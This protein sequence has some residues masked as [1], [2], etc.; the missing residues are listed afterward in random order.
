[1]SR[2]GWVRR[3]YLRTTVVGRRKDSSFAQMEYRRE[4]CVLQLDVCLQQNYW[5]TVVFVQMSL[6]HCCLVK[7][8]RD[9]VENEAVRFAA[10]ANRVPDCYG[11][12][13]NKLKPSVWQNG[14]FPCKNHGYSST[15]THESRGRELILDVDQSPVGHDSQNECE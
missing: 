7:S 10:V 1:M 14:E 2:D 11:V 5:K 6:L 4:Y 12:L 13:P 8:L 15:L 3:C 9:E